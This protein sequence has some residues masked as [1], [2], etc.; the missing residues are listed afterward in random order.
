[1]HA[2]GLDRL[3]P[4]L[5]PAWPALT[6]GPV[7]SVLGPLDAAGSARPLPSSAAKLSCGDVSVWIPAPE[8]PPEPGLAP[9]YRHG[10]RLLVMPHV[11]LFADDPQA[12]DPEYLTLAHWLEDALSRWR[13]PADTP[14]PLAPLLARLSPELGLPLLGLLLRY[15]LFGTDRPFRRHGITFPRL[16]MWLRPVGDTTLSRAAARQ[17]VLTARLKLED[18]ARQALPTT[19]LRA[20]AYRITP[21]A[22]RDFGLD[23]VHTPEGS[24]IRLLARL[25]TGVTIS[26][27]RRLVVPAGVEVPL[28]LSTSRIPFAG[29][30]DPRRL[31]MAANMQAQATFLLHPEPPLVRVPADGIDP[32]GTNLHVGY[33]A[34]RG[35]NHEDAWVLSESAAA[36]LTAVR[37]TTLSLVVRTIELPPHLHVVVGTQVVAG[38]LLLQRFAAAVLLTDDLTTLATLP[39]LD[40]RT[41][42]EPEPGD[43][44][45]VDG[46]V[47]AVEHWDLLTGEG[48]PAG[49]VIPDDVRAATRSIYRIT[50]RETL[51][52]EV[53]DK[54]ANRHGHKGVVGAILPDGEMPQV[55]GAPLEALIDPISVLNRSN[56]GQ[57][58]EARQGDKETRRQGGIFNGRQFIL[59]LPQLAREKA[60]VAPTRRTRTGLRYRQQRLGEMEHWALWAHGCGAGAGDSLS[61]AALELA[62][63]LGVA[64]IDLHRD[65]D[66]LV[67]QVL[68]LAGATPEAASFPV[69]TQSEATSKRLG[70]LP[71]RELFDALEQVSDP[72]TVLVFPDTLPDVPTPLGPRPVRWLPVLPAADRP[73]RRLHDG[74]EQPHDLTLAYR[75]VLRALRPWVAAVR[76]A[77]ASLADSPDAEDVLPE[78]DPDLSHLQHAIGALMR[79]AYALAVGQRATGP[80]SSKLAHLRRKVLGARLPGSARAVV[81]PAGSLHLDL[82]EI[83]LPESLFAALFGPDVGPAPT[84]WLKRDPVL[85]R[86]GLLAVRARPVPGHAVRLP[87]SLLGPLNADFDGDTVALFAALPGTL[88][89][90]ECRPQN[91]A[92]H[93][94]TGKALFVP[95]KQYVYGLSLLEESPDDLA[96]FNAALQELGAPVWPAGEKTTAARLQAWVIAASQHDEPSPAWWATAEAHALAALAA[97]PGMSLGL[98]PASELPHLR[99]VKCGAAK[100]LY[101][102]AVGLQLAEELLTGRGL[103]RYRRAAGAALPFD[104]IADVMVAAKNAIGRFGGALRRLLYALPDLTPED[105]RLAQTLTEQTTQKALSVKAGQPPVSV[106]EFERQLRRLLQGQGWDLPEGDNLARILEPLRPIWS[107]LQARLESGEHPDWLAWLRAPHELA[108]I[109]SRTPILRLPLSDL[110]LASWTYNGGARSDPAPAQGRN[111]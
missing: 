5:P 24:D 37:D 59:R 56:W 27:Q 15:A 68:D 12:A 51:P 21:A 36:K 90:P 53:G 10:D 49:A 91:N 35:L 105:V 7:V 64:G 57:L 29:Y 89:T 45:E 92:A 22:P 4:H 55:D 54:L 106:T 31:L 13:F 94:L 46:T 20:A 97:D 1:M 108:D 87:A 3:L 25:G 111:S 100:N 2:P 107:A 104:P 14:T 73:P 69:T 16:P 76:R 110:R 84:L 40:A 103:D 86:Y 78:A 102:D 98:Y 32:E 39:D 28:S 75:R 71:L 63:L 44:A 43:I 11:R 9:L 30:D 58:L 96:H 23:P 52:L 62:R 82:D 81:A 101:D 38:Q 6:A 17:L 50:L 42:L 80:D 109:L 61:E 47:L 18:P 60:T 65:G 72:T 74:S 99:A 8:V 19:D 83:G 41:P 26:P 34:W 33:L 79:E 93:D 70:V 88:P 66:H 95:G 85:H 77:G 48:V 67:V